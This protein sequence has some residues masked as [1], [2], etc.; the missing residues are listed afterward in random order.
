[1]AT[2]TGLIGV[3][4]TNTGWC[5]EN[6]AVDCASLGTSTA[7]KT[8]GQQFKVR[9]CLV[10]NF[11]TSG[12]NLGAGASEVIACEV[13][14]GTSTATAGIIATGNQGQVSNSN[15]HDNATVGIIMSG[16]GSVVARCLV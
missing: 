15:V 5:V 10:K 12:I 1:L 6:I 4:I 7:I 9:N 11:T 3:S 16:T 8:T 14:T 13:T 2:N